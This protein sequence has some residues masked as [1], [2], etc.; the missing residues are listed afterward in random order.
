MLVGIIQVL[1][2]EQTHL[3]DFKR[4]HAL[5]ILISLETLVTLTV[6]VW[7]LGKKKTTL[8][9]FREIFVVDYQCIF[10]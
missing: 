1:E 3:K 5:L 10:C 4:E 2:D 6:L 8:N 7:Y 9:N